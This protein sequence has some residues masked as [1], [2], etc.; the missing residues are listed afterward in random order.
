MFL[1]WAVGCG[2][3][4][5]TLKG[6]RGDV[7][8]VDWSSDNRYLRSVSSVYELFFWDVDSGLRVRAEIA[9]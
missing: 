6:H 2:C 9:L 4:G 7:L 8:Q 3:A 5:Q 1:L